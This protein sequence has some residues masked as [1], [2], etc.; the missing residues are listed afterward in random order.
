MFLLI[1]LVL[2]LQAA[3]WLAIGATAMNI[4]ATTS[5]N[6]GLARVSWQVPFGFFPVF[7]NSAGVLQHYRVSHV[8]LK[9]TDLSP[10]QVC[11]G[12]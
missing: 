3:E 4:G 8:S 11:L 6:T 12:E 10:A 9:E 5:V 1:S 2:A 7:S